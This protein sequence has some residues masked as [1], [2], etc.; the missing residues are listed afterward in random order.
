MYPLSCAMMI[1]VFIFILLFVF[2]AGCLSENKHE[3][4]WKMLALGLPTQVDP[5]IAAIN[6]GYYALK[7]THVPLFDL[8]ED[9]QFRSKVL[10]NWNRSS[11]SRYYRFCVDGTRFFNDKKP[12]D[13]QYLHEFLDR[14]LMRSKT[15]VKL[16]REDQCVIAHFEQPEKDLLIQLSKMENAPSVVTDRV[17]I[18]DGLGPFSVRSITKSE[19]HFIRKIFV[20]DGFNEIRMFNYLG[21]ADTHLNDKTIVDFNRV[22]VEELPDWVK[23]DYSDFGVALLQTINL[24]IDHQDPQVRKAVYNCVDIEK[25]RKAFMPGRDS[26]QDVATLLPVGIEGAMKGKA[27]QDRSSVGCQKLKNKKITFVNWKD[28]NAESLKKYFELFQE[29]SGIPVS[30]YSIALTEFASKIVHEPRDFN[31]SIVALDAVS[32]DITAFFGPLF[33]D[34][35]SV[36]GHGSADGKKLYAELKKEY[37]TARRKEILAELLKEI[38][39]DSIIL[40]L[41]QEVRTFYYPKYLKGLNMG[42]NFLEYPSI[43]EVRF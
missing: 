15:S 13:L 23:K 20:K 8:D 2:F 16:S 27:E 37:G 43:G 41:F 25:F 7:Q 26:F 3:S 29:K 33:G 10:S 34:P 12:F 35:I 19:I 31:L 17:N 5:S 38:K 14:F 9:G 1:K 36:L 24:L 39:S 6:M 11:D 18:E 32:P 21:S 30:V 4:T 42:Q 28:G 22:F 40:P